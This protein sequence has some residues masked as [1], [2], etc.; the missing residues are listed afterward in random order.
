MKNIISHKIDNIFKIIVQEAEKKENIALILELL[1]QEEEKFEISFLNIQSLPKEII[2][3]LHKIKN[4]LTIITNETILKTYLINLN[5]ELQLINN[6]NLKL[7]TLN[8]E[9]LAL[10]GSAGSLKKFIK[11]VENLPPSQISIFIIMHY[12][13]DGNS[14]LSSILQNKTIY[15]N[16][17]EAKSNMKIEPATIYTAPPGKHLIVVEEFI[18]L[19]DEKKRNFSKP[20]ISTTFETLSNEYKNNLLA[21]LLCGYGRDGSDSLEQLQQNGT[22]VI[23]EDPKECEAKLMLENAIE[24]GNYDLILSLKEINNYISY[25]LN[26]ELFDDKEVKILLNKIYD[27]YGYN[28]SEYNFE[29]IKRRIKL[30]YSTLKPSSFLEFQKIILENKNIFKDLFLNISVNV[31]TFYRNP[32]IFKILKEKL[33]HKLDSFID[34]KIWCAGCSSGEEPYSIAIFLKEL[35]LLDKSLIYATDLNEV[36]LS[37]AKNALYSKE[38]YKQFLK[39]YYQAGGNE[40]F[41]K[42]FNHY[43]SFVEVKEEIREKILFFRHNLVE[44]KRINDFQLIFC[45]NVLIY[46]NKDLKEKIFDLF[47]SSLDNYGFLILGESETVDKHDKFTAIDITN[48][49]YKKKT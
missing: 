24:T 3:A 37:N 1:K 18:F 9:Y 8:L 21:I 14:S 42:Y 4:K 23:I 30:F 5:F 25:F 12:K 39:H 19:T 22:T 44:D 16:V 34:I 28:Y 17:V 7:K 32:K 36:I 33:L 48:K 6:Q 47:E 46:F 20:S 26:S 38:S 41:S 29:H 13:P 2:I 35:G 40:S 27:K 11:I 49:I 43:D 15:Y 45:R 10:G 31:T